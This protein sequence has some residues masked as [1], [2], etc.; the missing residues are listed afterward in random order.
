MT[1]LKAIIFDLDGVIIDSEALH[2]EAGRMAMSRYALDAASLDFDAFKGKTEQDVFEYVVETNDADHVSVADLLALKQ[3]LYGNL[4][5]RLLPVQGALAFIERLA[6]AGFALGLTTS[7]LPKN[8]QRAFDK[9]DLHRYFDVVV[10]AAD[11][12]HAKPHPEPYLTTAQ[13]LGVAPAYCLVIEDSTH[14]VRSARRAGCRV[15][16]LTTTFGKEALAE[17][18]AEV[19]VD[20]YDELALHL[21][22]EDTP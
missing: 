12:T 22:W 18:G 9:F 16:G 17:A 21:H 20:R 2:E 15:A 7:S 19:V 5:D 10:T 6:Q 14:G 13:R 11:V 8:Q 4:L 1:D 3:R